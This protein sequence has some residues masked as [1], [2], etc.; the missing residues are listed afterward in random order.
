MKYSEFQKFIV[1]DGRSE[2][3][4][5]FQKVYFLCPECDKYAN[6]DILKTSVRDSGEN[7]PTNSVVIPSQSLVL[8]YVVLG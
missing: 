7:T 3:H 6:F 4:S 8:R 1:L 2:P 5:K